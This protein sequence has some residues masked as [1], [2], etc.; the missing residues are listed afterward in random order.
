MPGGG[1][2][3]FPCVL[4]NKRTKP[5]ERRKITT[6]ETHFL[7]KT[8][9]I[10]VK[11][12]NDTLCNRCRHKYYAAERQ[13]IQVVAKNDESN[14]EYIPTPKRPK[15]S[16][17]SS[18]P[19]ISLSIPSTP[20]SHAQCFLCKR[21]GPKLV[22]VPSNA[23][24]DV[25][26]NCEIIVP[27][28]SRCCPNHLENGE[29]KAD[30]LH[31]IKTANSSLLSRTSITELIKSLRTS[32]QQNENRR[33]DFET[34]S[35][36]T[37]ND[38]LNLTGIC[39]DAFDEI[40]ASALKDLRN[41]PARTTRTSLGIFLFKLKS[42]L[43]NKIL[44][45]IFNI[46]KSSLRRAI[47]SV[48]KSL[49]ASFVPQNLGL[50]HIS[51]EEVIEKHTKPLAQTLFGDIGNSQVILVLDGT[52]IYIQKSNNFH[53]QR[54][55]YSVHKG[56]P[57]VKAMVVVTTTGHFV[58]AVGPYLADNKNNDANIL[59]HMLKSNLEDIKHWVQENDIFVV[60]R[61]FRD[62]ISLLEDMGIKSEMPCFMK[63]GDKQLSTEDA[64][65][66]RLVTKVRWVV[67]SAN[68]RIKRWQYLDKVLPTNQVPYIGD[69]IRIVCAIS[70]KFLPPLSP[71]HDDDVAVAAKMLHL[72]R[73]V[74]VLKERVE[75][76]SLH[77]RKSSM[78]RD[79]STIDD[80]PKMT[81][82]QLR[83]MTCGSYQLKLSRCYI[84]EHLDGNHDIL[85]HREDPQL[86]KVK[87]Q[88]RHVSSKA[89]VL[90]ISYN[91][92]E[93]TA[94]YCLCKT[95]ARVVGVCTRCVRPVVSRVCQTQTG[96]FEYWG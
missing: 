52:Y 24:F 53:F 39:K 95:G 37:N 21:P 89:H 22:V 11:D 33:I 79:A 2:K 7:Q 17:L 86:L 47:A 64:N 94:W 81:E 66:S 84:Q 30:M 4:C 74:N 96:L 45:T 92:V 87:M 58:T 82:E 57:L 69:Y 26:M 76:E 18:P 9:L 63:R 80:F 83:E 41:T 48:R 43:S 31:S 10:T 49:V 62:A 91:E 6:Q 5:R 36:L 78:W 42:G 59:T 68:A 77:S 38:H 3:F 44:S 67:E 8:F 56:R 15:S 14:D 88:S 35:N 60:D 19:S 90:W 61:G 1:P 65:A 34:S 20:K 93:V 73:Q 16:A 25:F 23:R 32:A 70:N 75:A 71:A 28:G 27:A 54:R 12:T 51:R 40:C 55:S 85:V 72:S 46:S 50:Q 29:F 13:K